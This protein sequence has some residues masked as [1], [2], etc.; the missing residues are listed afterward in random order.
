VSSPIDD[1][2]DAEDPP[3]T[4]RRLLDV[5]VFAPLGF[6]LEY[7]SMVP[8]LSEAGRRQI[9]FTQSLGRAALRTIA[10]RTTSRV[11]SAPVREVTGP[12]SGTVPAPVDEVPREEAAVEGY[13]TMTARDIIVLIEASGTARVEWI[14]SRESIAKKRVTVL[15]AVESRR[16]RLTG[17]G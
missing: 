5:G 11:G 4:A 17:A 10:R 12:D 15:R 13:D 8:K 6:V 7:R 3:S 16:A 9:A 2:G 14:A 1:R